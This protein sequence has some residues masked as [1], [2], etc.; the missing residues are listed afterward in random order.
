MLNSKMM[1]C[2]CFRDAEKMA[3]GRFGDSIGLWNPL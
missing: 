3:S 2:S 1:S